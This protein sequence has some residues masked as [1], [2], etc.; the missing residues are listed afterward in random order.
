MRSSSLR[1]TGVVIAVAAGSFAPLA[2][3]QTFQNVLTED[4]QF[5]SDLV[6]TKDCGFQVIG[7]TLTQPNFQAYAFSARLT[8]GGKVAWAKRYSS[9]AG[10]RSNGFSC[11][12]STENNEL[13]LGCEYLGTPAPTPG[14]RVVIRTD[15]SGNPIWCVRLTGSDSSVA[16]SP[17]GGFGFLST[18]VS[19]MFK[20]SIAVI[21]RKRNTD[22]VVRVGL[23]TVLERDGSLKFS[24]RYVPTGGSDAALDFIQ[25]RE[26]RDSSGEVLVLGTLLISTN[27]YAVFAMRT[28]ADGK[29]L[30]ARSYRHPDGSSDLVGGGFSLAANGDMLFSAARSSAPV[31][32]AVPYNGLCGRIDAATGDLVWSSTVDDFT[33]GQQ[34][35]TS[36]PDDSMLVAGVRGQVFAGSHTDTGGAVVRIDPLGHTDR[37]WSFGDLSFDSRAGFDAIASIDCTGGYAMFGRTQEVGVDRR[38]WTVRADANFVSGCHEEEVHASGGAIELNVKLASPTV[39]ADSGYMIETAVATDVNMA[40]DFLCSR[41][42][43]IGDLN[44]DYFVDDSDFVLFAGAYDTLLCPTNPAYTCCPADF[45]NDGFVDDSDF[46]LFA[47]A[48][49]QLICP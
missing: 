18:G 14:S 22:G 31:A 46:V 13:V 8:E 30:W 48:Y 16:L 32:G 7:Q 41:S 44:A 29:I 2:L 24:N 25:A 10:D 49:D 17:P 11:F 37:H 23:L 26:A 12:E 33:N 4:T 36:L 27:Y 34:S 39:I 47:G 45:D 42:R 3:G 43:C 19:E 21:G 35:V 15:S 20:N 28:D 6:N 9:A 38:A 40:A 1:R 5:G